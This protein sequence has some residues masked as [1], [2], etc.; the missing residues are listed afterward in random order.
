M[1]DNVRIKNIRQQMQALVSGSANKDYKII[2]MSNKVEEIMDKIDEKIKIFHQRNT[3][4]GMFEKT[5]TDTLE[6]ELSV[7]ETW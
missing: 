4:S 1:I 3:L 2:N 5:L 7:L 6:L